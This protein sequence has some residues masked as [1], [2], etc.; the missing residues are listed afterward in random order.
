MDGTVN[1]GA[2]ENRRVAVNGV[3]VQ[4]SVLVDG[5]SNNKQSRSL[6]LNAAKPVGFVKNSKR[7]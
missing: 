2:I 6:R 5:V 1:N 4:H 3:Y 7:G